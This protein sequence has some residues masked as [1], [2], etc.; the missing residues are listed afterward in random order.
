MSVQSKSLENTI[1]FLDE[2]W[3]NLGS[4]EPVAKR[5]ERALP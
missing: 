1:I 5:K 4:R 2:L 3:K